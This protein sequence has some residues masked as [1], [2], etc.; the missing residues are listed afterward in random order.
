MTTTRNTNTNTTDLKQIQYNVQGVVQGVNYRSWAADK[1]KSCGVTGF[2]KNAS[3][4]S[5]TGEAQGDDSGLQ[6]F[7]QFLNSGPSAAEV[8]KVEQ[9]E[10]EIKS[11]E[12]GF[13]NDRS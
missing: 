3:D 4:G 12:S 6:K 5:V 10:I 9:K 7:V 11:G 2:V 13:E 1:A 8:R